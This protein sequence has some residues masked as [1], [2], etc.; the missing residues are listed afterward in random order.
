MKFSLKI[1]KKSGLT[2]GKSILYILVC[3]RTPSPSGANK[4]LDPLPSRL[5]E[6]LDSPPTV[7]DQINFETPSLVERQ[8]NNIKTIVIFC[9]HSMLSR[10]CVPLLIIETGF[11]TIFPPTHTHPPLVNKIKKFDPPPSPYLNF[12]I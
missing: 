11:Y 3:S 2:A 5:N 1:A 9:V 7:V 10:R 6:L 8:T 12:K 4:L